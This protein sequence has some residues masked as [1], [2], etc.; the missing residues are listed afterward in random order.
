MSERIYLLVLKLYPRRFR[1]SYGDEA[2]HL[3]RDRMRDETGLLRRVRLWF[4]LLSDLAAIHVRGYH[5]AAAV[6]AIVP[7]QSGIPAFSSLDD[8]AFDLR[9]VLMGAVLAVIVCGGV[10][11]ALDSGGDLSFRSS[12]THA[13]DSSSKTKASMEFSYEPAHP[14][15]GSVVRFSATVSGT[16]SGPAPTGRVRFVDGWI[17]LAD[18]DLVH[19]SVTV[20]ARLPEGKT[21]PLN[22]FYLGDSN[23]GPAIALERNR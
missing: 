9:F 13:V 5:E 16:G 17:P 21:F 2:L 10:F 12:V 20:V 6:Q 11:R 14:V 4:D 1:Q 22:A 19:G 18:G 7:V 3:F 23:Y 8:R 15:A